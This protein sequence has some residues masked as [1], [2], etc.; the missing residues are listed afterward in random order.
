MRLVA[1]QEQA[2]A[3]RAASWPGPMI[4][5]RISPDMAGMPAEMMQML[6]GAPQQRAGQ[7]PAATGDHTCA[8]C[9]SATAGLRY[10]SPYSQILC[11]SIYL[12]TL[13]KLRPASHDNLLVVFIGLHF[14][15][16]Y[17]LI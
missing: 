13:T 14:S 15:D 6:M 5:M 16:L 9:N 10:V 3:A 4:Q 7:E 12:D 8:G 2:A 1:A 11:S 17:R